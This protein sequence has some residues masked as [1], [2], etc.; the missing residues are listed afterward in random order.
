M[1]LR[2]EAMAEESKETT[3][4]EKGFPFKPWVVSTYFAEGFPY[5]VVRQISTVFFKDAGA[6]LQ[7]IGLTSLYGLPWVLKFLWGPLV[8]AFSTKRRW[9][10]TFEVFL[11]SA[12]LLMA[13]TTALP[14]PL[15]IMAVLFLVVAFLSATHDIAIDGFYLESLNKKQQA[16]YVGYQA[17]SY[18]LA[19]IAGGGGVVAFSGYTSWSAAFLLA[20]GILGIL[21]LY[22]FLFLP[23]VQSPARPAY[24][25]ARQ[26]GKPKTILWVLAGV[27]LLFLGRP[28]LLSKAVQQ[29]IPR[30]IAGAFLLIILLILLFLPR[31]KRKMKGSDSFYA[32][33]F[34]DYLDQPKIGFIL[35]FV[36]LYRTGESFLLNMLYPFL[37][38]IGITAK[39]QVRGGRHETNQGSNFGTAQPGFWSS[40]CRPS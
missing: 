7:A 32:R 19:L 21:L 9:L 17:M 14:S 27:I 2:E 8:D 16:K 36:L 20:A 22:H 13:A 37:K 23:R 12:V 33:A 38:D 31:L 15:R 30:I 24:E 10:V 35:C 1:R 28:L 6:S 40:W 39:P 26:L 4:E 11:V 5:S 34:I 25:M 29:N 18:R 3:G